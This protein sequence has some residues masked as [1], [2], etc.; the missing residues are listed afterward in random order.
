MASLLSELL[1][2]KRKP[3][4]YNG[5]LL[6]HGR[7]VVYAHESSSYNIVFT[8]SS[9][10]SK[11]PATQVT[12][13]SNEQVSAEGNMP[14]G[15]EAKP[16]SLETLMDTGNFTEQTLVECLLDFDKKYAADWNRNPASIKES[17]IIKGYDPFTNAIVLE[18][19]LYHR[20]MDTQFHRTD[21]NYNAKATELRTQLLLDYINN[22]Y[23][24]Y[25]Y[26]FNR[27]LMAT[28]MSSYVKGHLVAG[29]FQPIKCGTELIRSPLDYPVFE[30]F[31][32]ILYG[33][34]YAITDS[35]G[36][37]EIQ[38]EPT[39]NSNRGII[40]TCASMYDF[41]CRFRP[42]KAEG[43]P[44]VIK[45]MDKRVFMYIML[46]LLSGVVNSGHGLEIPLRKRHPVLY[47]DILVNNLEYRTFALDVMEAIKEMSSKLAVI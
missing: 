43:E 26:L 6:M 34:S 10:N 24:I 30:E 18:S 9:R 3:I 11:G 12:L 32:S 2:S 22:Y 13:S 27:R 41:T 35:L 40:L 5:K 42:S 20:M 15:E 44:H 29:L 46:L 38:L 23:D 16:V 47:N 39:E 33:G 25:T 4:I 1:A 8:Y 45:R 17:S 14:E 31:R 21:R 37:I 36:N 19:E 28:H 7:Q